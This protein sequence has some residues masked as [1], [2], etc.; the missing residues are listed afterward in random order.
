MLFSAGCSKEKNYDIYLGGRPYKWI[1][2]NFSPQNIKL[3][4]VYDSDGELYRY[5]IEVN[6][7]GGT[8]VFTTDKSIH[9]DFYINNEDPPQLYYGEKISVN[10]DKA[11]IISKEWC[12]IYVSGETIRFNFTPFSKTDAD[13]IFIQISSKSNIFCFYIIPT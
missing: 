5:D 10:P 4:D 2:T 1:V 13:K 12:T 11:T 6:E 8:V 3:T 7:N 9:G